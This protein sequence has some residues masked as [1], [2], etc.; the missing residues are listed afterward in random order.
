MSYAPSATLACI[1]RP[2][3]AITINSAR[4]EPGGQPA[5]GNHNRNGS[6]CAAIRPGFHR[7]DL[8]SLDPQV[9]AHTAPTPQGFNPTGTMPVDC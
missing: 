2:N 8:T 5:I 4:V 1:H 9:P 7:A 3:W 6:I